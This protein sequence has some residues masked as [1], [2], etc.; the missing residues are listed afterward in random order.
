MKIKYSEAIKKNIKANNYFP[1]KFRAFG[2][3]GDEGFITPFGTIM[4][5]ADVGHH[6]LIISILTDEY[7]KALTNAVRASGRTYD[8]IM[9]NE[10]DSVLVADALD[11]GFIRFSANEDVFM[12]FGP[13]I[14]KT[15]LDTL[16]DLV[17]W[18]ANFKDH[19]EDDVRGKFCCRVVFNSGLDEK[20]NPK[21]SK[22][23]TQ[24]TSIDDMDRKLINDVKKYTKI[25]T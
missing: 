15:S 10:D 17:D 3:D 14:T 2:Y 11:H 8:D 9:D 20:G 22:Q 23:Y 1:N 21:Y 5:C 12:E 16:Y 19:I 24:Y 4:H 13:E 25:L 18:I 6:Y 7:I